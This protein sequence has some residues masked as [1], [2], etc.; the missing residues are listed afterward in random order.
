[1]VAIILIGAAAGLTLITRSPTGSLSSSSSSTNATTS[2]YTNASVTQ[3]ASSS[4]TSSTIS[5]AFVSSTISSSSSTS[6]SSSSSSS[7]SSQT[8][9]ETSTS[10]S[11]TATTSQSTS[12]SN[13][14]V[15]ITKAVAT[16]FLYVPYNQYTYAITGG[17]FLLALQGSSVVQ[18]YS[19]CSGCDLESITLDSQNNYIYA[20]VSESSGYNLVSVNIATQSL[21]MSGSSPSLGQNAFSIA[22]AS[23]TNRLYVLSLATQYRTSAE[24][25]IVDPASLQVTGT[26][27]GCCAQVDNQEYDPLLLYNSVNHYIY[28]PYDQVID[29][30][31]MSVLQNLTAPSGCIIGC[32]ELDYNPASGDTYYWAGDSSGTGVYWQ[33]AEI[34]DV[35]PV[36]QNSRGYIIESHAEVE[37]IAYD[38]K[39]G[40]VYA[41]VFGVGQRYSNNLTTVDTASGAITNVNSNLPPGLLN[42]NPSSNG[43]Y[44]SAPNI[45]DY[46]NWGILYVQLS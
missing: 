30:I 39:N 23:I 26:I 21:V 24:M 22:Y 29:P 10:S 14:N 32:A 34:Y 40:L 11:T 31:T 17:Q 27:S 42:Y 2:T 19:V 12:S 41:S 4:S 5:N 9:S 38:S 18:N 36:T 15:P 25:F 35:N 28:T 3:A 20:L 37:G 16:Q 46:S 43:L 13:P 33:I 8:S 1:V 7:L 44:I 6:S 45:G